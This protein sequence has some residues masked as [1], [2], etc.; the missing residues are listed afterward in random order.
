MDCSKSVVG[1]VGEVE[2]DSREQIKDKVI[3]YKV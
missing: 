2:G 3:G 1:V